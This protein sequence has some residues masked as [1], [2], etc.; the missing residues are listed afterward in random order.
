VIASFLPSEREAIDEETA[1]LM[2]NLLEGVVNQG[3]ACRLRGPAYQLKNEMGGKTG[4]TQ[5]N[6]DG[7][8]MSIMPN[9][10]TG[11]WVGGEDRGIHF[12]DM[13]IGQAANTAVPIFG[14]FIKKVFASDKITSVKE[15]D[16]F[17]APEHFGYTL[18]CSDRHISADESDGAIEASVTTDESGNDDGSIFNF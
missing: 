7:W 2:V 3:T 14:R 13:R 6:S 16:T 12:D 18:D 10:V 17:E 8:Y 1:F 5:N 4:T 15:D 9:L 11:V